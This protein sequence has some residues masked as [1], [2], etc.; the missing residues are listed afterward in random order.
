[1]LAEKLLELNIHEMKYMAI[2]TKQRVMKT[3]GINPLKLNMDWPSIK[4]D[5]QGTWPP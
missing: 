3:T 5:S 1:M 2:S 4:N